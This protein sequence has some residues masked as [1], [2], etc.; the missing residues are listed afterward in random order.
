LPATLVAVSSCFLRLFG[1]YDTC[2]QP[3]SG[4]AW[5]VELK[6]ELGV[7]QVVHDP[8]RQIGVGNAWDFYIG[9]SAKA[10]V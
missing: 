5:R 4:N 1:S 6:D 9:G 2:T 8:L 3:L 10:M 7:F